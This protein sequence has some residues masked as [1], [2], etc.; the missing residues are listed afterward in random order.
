M[1]NFPQ[2]ATALHRLFHENSAGLQNAALL[3]GGRPALKR[4]TRIIDDLSYSSKIGGRTQRDI[5]ALHALLTLSNV[6]DED[7]PEASY[8]AELDPAAPYIEEICLLA[9]QLEAAMAET[10]IVSSGSAQGL[11]QAASLP[12][13][14]IGGSV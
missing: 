8:F 7:R 6:H 3:R 5:E 10:G 4:V 1:F 9:D 13:K 14:K 12:L 2:S 11:S